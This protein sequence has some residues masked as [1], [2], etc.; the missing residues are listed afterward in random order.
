MKMAEI[1]KH[2]LFFKK[3][4]EEGERNFRKNGITK[5]GK[6]WERELVSR[7]ELKIFTSFM[8]ISN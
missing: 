1:K 6:N 3:R 5:R 4:R 2:D 7:L 8:G